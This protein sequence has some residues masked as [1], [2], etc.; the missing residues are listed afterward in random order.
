MVMHSYITKWSGEKNW[1]L[2][3]HFS[4][5]IL[6]KMHLAYLFSFTF[7]LP[8]S[9]YYLVVLWAGQA[10]LLLLQPPL[11][12]IKNIHESLTLI[13]ECTDNVRKEK[14]LCEI[15]TVPIT[16]YVNSWLNGFH[17]RMVFTII[18]FQNTQENMFK[19][20]F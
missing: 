4:I 3:L 16:L 18:I 8:S 17:D 12:K 2:H 7:L 10:E 15:L 20:F 9:K 14:Y 1:Q 19:R 11:F 5:L 6:Q 13:F